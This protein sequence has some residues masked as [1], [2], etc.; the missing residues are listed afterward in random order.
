MWI[1]RG[2]RGF[3]SSTAVTMNWIFLAPGLPASAGACNRTGTRPG[4]RA[5]HGHR[6]VDAD[7]GKARHALGGDREPL[8]RSPPVFMIC[9]R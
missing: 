7:D 1:S 8:L 5:A 9:R 2:G 6:L 3:G 4:G